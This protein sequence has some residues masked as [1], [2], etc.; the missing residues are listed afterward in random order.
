MAAPPHVGVSTADRNYLPSLVFCVVRSVAA[1]PLR[2]RRSLCFPPAR[3]VFRV[4][5]L[6]LPLS[7]RRLRAARVVF[8]LHNPMVINHTTSA[9]TSQPNTPAPSVWPQ[10]HHPRV[11]HPRCAPGHPPLRRRHPSLRHHGD[12]PRSLS[13]LPD[14]PAGGVRFNF[15]ASSAAQ[16]V[17]RRR[18]VRRQ[19]AGRMGRTRATA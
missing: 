13:S 16:S 15:E 2:A 10:G 4:C 3:P 6:A 5:S 1:R 14:A 9:S 12:V 17:A 8:L 11:V 7:A 18:L 19:P